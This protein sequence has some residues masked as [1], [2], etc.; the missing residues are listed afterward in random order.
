M[1]YILE[2]D[3]PNI[4]KSL[5]DNN[6]RDEC[7]KLR[8]E[9][10]LLSQEIQYLKSKLKNENNFDTEVNEEEETLLKLHY[11][12]R[13]RTLNKL[14]IYWKTKSKEFKEA[15]NECKIESENIK[16]SNIK[17]VQVIFIIK[18]GT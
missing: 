2:S 11:E 4:D 10:S 13:C 12:R 18:I 6:I 17:L 7:E 5:C 9:N 14:V 3:H 15:L 16:T 8:D 1:I